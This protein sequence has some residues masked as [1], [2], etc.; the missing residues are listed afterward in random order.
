MKAAERSAYIEAVDQVL[1]PLGFS[2]PKRSQE[3]RKPVGN[4]DFLWVHLNFGLGVINPS[5]GVRYVDL[6]SLL[7]PEAGAVV[8]SGRTLSSLSGEQYSLDTSASQ[9][10][11]DFLSCG[12]PELLALQDRCEVIRRLEST[13]AKDWP[14]A[15]ASH[16][17]RLLPLLLASQ[18]RTEESSAWVAQFETQ[19]DQMVPGYASFAQFFRSAYGAWP[20][21]P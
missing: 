13:A 16:R 4:Q 3:W 14:V 21:R 1:F 2:R 7:P 10:A 15:S 20:H 19:A 9:L 18:G 6:E 12:M 8:S 5:F 11:E 17:M